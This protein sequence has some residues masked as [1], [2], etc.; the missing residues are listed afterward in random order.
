MRGGRWGCRWKVEVVV[1]VEV[2]VGVGGEKWRLEGGRLRYKVR[3]GKKKW[4]S[5][6][7]RGKW[8]GRSEVRGGTRCEV[9]SGKSRVRVGGKE[10][11]VEGKGDEGG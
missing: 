7:R 11:E 2:E 8:P 10:V 6:K 3:G 5:N 9:R 1:V 4:L